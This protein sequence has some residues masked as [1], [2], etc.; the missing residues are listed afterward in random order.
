MRL[1]KVFPD[2]RPDPVHVAEFE[3]LRLGHLLEGFAFG[4][5]QKLAFFVEQL[6]GIPLLGIVGSRQDDAAVRLFEENGHF[7]GRRRGQPGVHHVHATGEQSAG[8]DAVHHFA[9]DAGVPS[10]DHLAVFLTREFLLQLAGVSRR[11]LDNVNGSERVADGAANGSANAGDRFD[12]GHILNYLR[13]FL[14]KI[15]YLAKLK[16]SQGK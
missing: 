12:E 8:Y 11:K 10:Y 2:H 4:I 1:R 7:S 15:Y 16:K 6:E 14:Q 13:F 3:I 5:G 9:R